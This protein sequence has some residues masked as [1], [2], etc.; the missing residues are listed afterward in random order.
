MGRQLYDLM[1]M[2]L[3]YQVLLCPRP[4]DVLLVTFNHLDTIKG[5]IQDNPALLHLVDETLRQLIEVRHHQFITSEPHTCSHSSVK[6]GKILWQREQDEEW[7]SLPLSQKTLKIS[8]VSILVI[9]E[10][11]SSL[12]LLTVAFKIGKAMI[13]SLAFS[14]NFSERG[15]VVDVLLNLGERLLRVCGGQER[16]CALLG[17]ARW[18]L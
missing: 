14:P 18:G 13:Q 7:Q 8:Q 16:W 15:L 10:A 17:V 5:L 9:Q 2:A 3:K 12:D 1:T 6:N 11:L 4:K